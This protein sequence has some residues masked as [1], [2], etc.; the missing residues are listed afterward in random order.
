MGSLRKNSQPPPFNFAN[1]KSIC[2]NC[3][4]RKIRN[5]RTE[6]PGANARRG[7]KFRYGRPDSL[8]G[9]MRLTWEQV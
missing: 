2:H 8:A 4:S 6:L 5:K 7:A 3:V 9:I 1:G